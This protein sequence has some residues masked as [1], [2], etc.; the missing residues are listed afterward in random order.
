[1]RHSHQQ[2]LDDGV[3]VPALVVHHFDVVQVGVCPVH[4]PADQ[5]QRDAV[6]EH[7]LT[8]HQL[9]S[10]LAVHVAALHLWDLTVVGEEHL[11]VGT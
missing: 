11:P 3:P 4:Q 5:V 6:R 9:G 8:V 2:P 1:M 10:V 7:N